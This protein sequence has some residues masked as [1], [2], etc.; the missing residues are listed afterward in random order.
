V[1]DAEVA[2]EV[3]SL[4]RFYERRK[5]NWLLAA[6]F[7]L[8]RHNGGCLHA[9]YICQRAAQKP[10]DFERTRNEKTEAKV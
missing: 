1:S 2:R 10:H 6:E 9:C 4:I 7:T 3:K 5:W 8:L